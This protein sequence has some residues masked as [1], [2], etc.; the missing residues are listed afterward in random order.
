M[1]EN[2]NQFNYTKQ[3]EHRIKLISD[4]LEVIKKF[5]NQEKLSQ[6]FET[7]ITLTSDDAYCNIRNIEIAC[8]LNNNESLSWSAY[9][10]SKL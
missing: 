6:I 4:D 2:V 7:K 5:I 9:N 8:D 1:K 10:N 3:L